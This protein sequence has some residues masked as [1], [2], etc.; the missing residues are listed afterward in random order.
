[1][2]KTQTTNWVQLR[3]DRRL[4]N[5]Q[6]SSTKSGDQLKIKDAYLADN[7]KVLRIQVAAT[8]AGLITRNYGFYLPAKMKDSIPSWTTPYKKP[9]QVHHRDTDDPI[10]RVVAARY[11]DTFDNF[12][13]A[14]K[15]SLSKG[16]LTIQDFQRMDP[17]LNPNFYMQD[18]LHVVDELLALGILQD[19]NYSG[20]GYTELTADITDP[21]AIQKFLDG[22]Y[23]TGSVGTATNQAI[24]SIKDCRRDWAGE[25][26]PCDHRPGKMYDGIPMFIVAGSLKNEEW[27]VVN[28]PAD[29]YS[30]V[31]AYNWNGQNYSQ[32]IHASDS[33]KSTDVI[34]LTDKDT[35][36]LS[37][38]IQDAV[39]IKKEDNEM[40]LV[41]L[42]DLLSL[43]DQEQL[44]PK[45]KDE[46]QTE[47]DLLRQFVKDNF[48][49]ESAL[50]KL[51][52]LRADIPEEA[53]QDALKI[54]NGI[55]ELTDELTDKFVDTINQ[56]S[57]ENYSDDYGDDWN[58]DLKDAKLSTEQRKKLAK[59]TFCGPN[60]SFPVPDCAHVTAARR[61]IGR[62]KASAST[63]TRILACVSRKAKAMGCGDMNDSVCTVSNPEALNP[64][65][66][67]QF[68][69]TSLSA[70]SD[71]SL[72]D[73][74]STVKSVLDT[75]KIKSELFVTDTLEQELNQ[76]KVKF[77]ELQKRYSE[78][79]DS[80]K[81]LR[82]ELTRAYEDVA[83]MEDRL[84]DQNKQHKNNMLHVMPAVKALTDKIELSAVSLADIET[85]SVEEV[86]TELIKITDHLD[87]AKIVGKLNDGLSREPT[88]TVTGPN[89]ATIEPNTEQKKANDKPVI[90]RA[91]FDAK[92]F[93]IY[94]QRGK[95]AA[96][97]YLA[98][99]QQHLTIK[100]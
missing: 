5:L 39:N 47:V 57:W 88:E 21:E 82:R 19:P 50:A 53:L 100:D 17:V 58:E 51:K 37:V 28:G 79:E 68:D 73:L 10:G 69:N 66:T 7:H 55:T 87:V 67:V 64:K 77:D 14:F 16:K 45:L 4:S 29:P 25:E 86:A 43:I 84:I 96:N 90:T 2:N 32:P 61:L 72:L 56:L 31:L 92:A 15:D 38:V 41:T 12:T 1:M 60:R 23:L 85:K 22:R 34:V 89:E 63:K 48:N 75:K 3:D 42:S 93:E 35:A 91:E 9:I 52:E 27:S 11:V 62:A 95:D 8:H 44:D 33:I 65:V 26:G 76:Q 70:M 49:S 20:L 13:S 80:L 6:F 74:V 99:A 18:S 83:V 78:L 46:V 36:D 81:Y 24:C 40:T 54:F 94:T 71:S 98:W 30:K 97:R 59:S